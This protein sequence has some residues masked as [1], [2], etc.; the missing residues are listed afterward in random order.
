MNKYVR[1]IVIIV[2]AVFLGGFVD[3]LLVPFIN[4]HAGLAAAFALLGE[5]YLWKQ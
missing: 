1:P 4:A 3:I 5:R 2:G